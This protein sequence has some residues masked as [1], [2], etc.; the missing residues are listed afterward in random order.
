MP[1]RNDNTLVVTSDFGHRDISYG[2]KN[3]KGID[4][5][6]A[7]GTDVYGTEV[8]GIVVGC[9]YQGASGGKAGG[10][11]YV[12]VAYPR[13]DGSYDVTGYLHLSTVDVKVGGNLSG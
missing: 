12:Y 10:G 4:F 9:G 7:A 8:G 13:K 3:H 6:A 2:S 1:L 5:R 11:N